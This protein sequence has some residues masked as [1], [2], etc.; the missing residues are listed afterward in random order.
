VCQAE[1]GNAKVFRCAYH[2][3]T[4]RNNGDLAGITYQDRY[5]A[6]F[7]EEDHGLRKAPRMG[8]YRGFVFGSL[9]PVGITLD[10]HLGQRVKEQ[11][12]LFVDL[13]PEVN[14]MLRQEFTNTG[15]GRIG[16]SRWKIAWTGIMP[17]LSIKSFFENVRRRTG[18]NLTDLRLL[19]P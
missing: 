10:E 5:D 3:W 9:R 14:W 8:I 12:D 16:S 19:S 15:T 6:L 18:V 2:G 1:R 4:Y 13:S 17:I 11:I 7:R